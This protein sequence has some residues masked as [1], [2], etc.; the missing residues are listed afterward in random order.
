MPH[1]DAKRWTSRYNSALCSRGRQLAY[2]HR[3]KPRLPLLHERLEASPLEHFE[4]EITAGLGRHASKI[5]RQFNEMHG[6]VVVHFGHTAHVGG[7]VGHYKRGRLVAERFQQLLKQRFV[8][9]ISLDET[10]T[11]NR[12]PLDVYRNDSPSPM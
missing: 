8:R 5:Q 4:Q 2:L 1:H 12:I 9:E 3:R 10:D 11:G 6:S 7:H